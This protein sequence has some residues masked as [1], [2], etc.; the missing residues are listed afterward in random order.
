MKSLYVVWKFFKDRATGLGWDYEK[1]T[2][3]ADNDWWKQTIEV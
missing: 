3:T 1:Q 2:V